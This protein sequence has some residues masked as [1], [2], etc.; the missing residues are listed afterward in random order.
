MEATRQMPGR[1]QHLRTCQVFVVADRAG[2]HFVS[3]EQ[4]H[5]AF[6]TA[7]C[8]CDKDGGLTTLMCA[9]DF[10]HPITKRRGIRAR[11]DR[12]H[13]RHLCRRVRVD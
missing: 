4:L 9:S 12:G 11:A 2:T 8:R 3:G 6:C 5:R 13:G 10:I 1:H 7:L